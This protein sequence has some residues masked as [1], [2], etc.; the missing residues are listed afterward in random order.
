MKNWKMALKMTFGFGQVIILLIVTAVMAITGIMGIIDNA[1]TVIA[2]NQLDGLLAQKEVEHLNWAGDVNALLTDSS[3]TELDVQLDDHQCAFGKWL[4]GSGRQEAEALV[5]SLAPLLKDIEEP[6]F[7][8]HESAAVIKDTFIQADMDI[9]SILR[10]REIEHLNWAGSIRDALLAGDRE[11]NV[12]TDPEKC[13]LGK[14]LQSETA[15]EMYNNGSTEFQKVWNEM[16]ENHEKLHSSAIELGSLMASDS[17]RALDFFNSTTIVLL[18]NTISSID[19]LVNVAE[20]DCNQMVAAMDIYAQ[21]TKP[22]LQEVQHKLNA[23][24]GEMRNNIMT[25]E[26]MIQAAVTTR[27]LVILISVIALV[28]GLIF[29]VIISRGITTPLHKGMVFAGQLAKGDL[30]ADIDLNQRDELGQ[31]ADSLREMKQSLVDVV[32]EVLGGANNVTSGSMQLSAT[33]QQLSQGA[34]EQAASTEEV[35]ASME[36]MDSS[37]GQ[38][39]DNASQTEAIARDALGV[40][41]DGSEAVLQTVDAMKNIAE[42]I[43]IIEDIARQ[44]NMLSLNAAIEAARAGEHGK[45]FAVVASEVGKLASQ[46][47]AA[48]NEISELAT[49][50]V[51][52]ADKTGELMKS[53]VPK[54]Q[55]T[56]D[57]I[58]E[59]NASSSEQR[60]GA[61]QITQAITQLDQV[62]Q[63]NASAS[64]ESAS[65]AEE[66]SA[67]AEKLQQTMTFFKIDGTASIKSSILKK[68]EATGVTLKRQ[69]PRI[70]NKTSA[71]ASGPEPAD[72]T[73]EAPSADTL[74]DE[75]EEY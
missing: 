16:L 45:G 60:S 52:L 34:S 7:H 54:M 49:S 41:K 36:E 74:D 28:V 67:Q 39:A 73:Y 13:G 53:V 64:E 10:Q 21:Q 6:H 14:W 61:Y 11:L 55:Q 57:L 19:Y 66:L 68:S 40:V 62:V 50:S 47:K 24:R 71:A 23:I 25:D 65:M 15:V 69:Q 27:R 44:T 46:S 72:K 4:Y 3:I 59:I 63:Q 26:Q 58:Q 35:S 17:A 48:A 33:A 9:P 75:F 43:S 70:E 2:G 42:K 12:E 22:A 56:A 30:T 20:N 32:T 51:S 8:L 1:G 38:N 31:L 29:A 37:I 18:N 5:P